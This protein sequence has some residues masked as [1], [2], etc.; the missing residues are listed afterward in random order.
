MRSSTKE[1]SQNRINQLQISIDQLN[2]EIQ[3]TANI[4]TLYQL[5]NEKLQSLD[6]KVIRSENARRTI[7]NRIQDIKG[8]ISC[9]A[10][11]SPFLHPGSSCLEVTP[12]ETKVMMR[13]PIGKMIGY[14]YDR[15]FGGNFE[16]EEIVET[17]S[18]LFYTVL[19]GKTITLLNY[20]VENLNSYKR[21]LLFGLSFCF[22]VSCIDS[23]SHGILHQTITLLYAHTQR[24]LYLQQE[25]HFYLSV[26]ELDASSIGHALH[27]SFIDDGVSENDI[28]D[29]PEIHDLLEIARFSMDINNQNVHRIKRREIRT[30]EDLDDLLALISQK[31]NTLPVKEML[32]TIVTL[33]N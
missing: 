27:S 29:E 23:S 31:Q 16:N 15:I 7:S 21:Q 10:V 30:Q 12:D 24:L 13:N 8:N 6:S 3:N 9:F 20:G 5:Q 33:Y 2:K 22:L 18:D 4:E 26:V 32:T 1:N 11:L 25:Y 17:L 14:S 28:T 19:D